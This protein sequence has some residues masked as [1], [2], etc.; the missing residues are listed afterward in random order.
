MVYAW[1][2]TCC[3]SQRVTESLIACGCA[4]LQEEARGALKE[5]ARLRTELALAKSAGL[6]SEAVRLDSG[7]QMLVARLD[8]ADS[9]SLQV[10][11]VVPQ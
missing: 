2:G 1:T 4:A 5:L 3:G 6:A 8:G 10:Q 11:T 7:A 9:K